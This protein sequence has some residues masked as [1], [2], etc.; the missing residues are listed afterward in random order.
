MSYNLCFAEVRRGKFEEKNFDM[1]GLCSLLEGQTFVLLPKSEIEVKGVERIIEVDLREESFL[2][3]LSLVVVFEE[4]RKRYGDPEFLLFP[5]S[6]FG[7]DV[8][9]YMAGYFGFS[10]L[11]DLSSEREGLLLKPF[12]SEKALAGFQFEAPPPY[13]LTVRS[14]SFKGLA[15]KEGMPE[16]EQ[17]R[18][19]ILEEKRSF[20]EYVS[21][22]TPDVDISKADFL[23]SIGRGVGSRE[24]IPS[25]EILAQRLKATLSASRPVIDKMWLPKSRQ[26]GI[27][28]RTVRPKVYFAMGISGSFQHIQGMKDAECIIA[29][30]RDP[31]APIFQYA[32][33]GVVED[34]HRVRDMLLELLGKG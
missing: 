12:F 34:M 31:N 33:F 17:L 20:V 11:S 25:Y 7:M 10:F 26:V 28:G 19:A 15:R 29:V 18:I 32:H 2:S 9:P 16:R 4:V 5:H 22:E 13:V 23:L 1:L 24:E 6:S 14:G 27:S 3:P 30:N 21:E 8:A